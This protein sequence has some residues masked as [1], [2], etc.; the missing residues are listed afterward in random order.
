MLHQTEAR[1]AVAATTVA[2]LHCVSGN[3]WWASGAILIGTACE[4]ALDPSAKASD[5]APAEWCWLHKLRIK[6]LAPFIG[7]VLPTFAVFLHRSQ[8]RQ[9]PQRQTC[10]QQA[11]NVAK[12]VQ[13]VNEEEEEKEMEMEEGPE[14]RRAENE[15]KPGNSI[16]DTKY[17]LPLCTASLPSAQQE[18][19]QLSVLGDTGSQ[20]I[21]LSNC[22]SQSAA[23]NL[24]G[25][26][27]FLEQ[28]STPQ[29]SRSS[30]NCSP[31]EA[32]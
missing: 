7:G 5:R 9:R 11:R 13:L 24:N 21:N 26:V 3:L 8:R 15:R 25:A 10:C 22:S 23:A 17:C 20:A 19:Q 12:C 18:A 6:I 31:H 1:A 32:A 16:K 30:S 4:K 14:D 2:F 29:V 27:G 28:P